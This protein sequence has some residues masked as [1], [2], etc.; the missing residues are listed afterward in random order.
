MLKKIGTIFIFKTRIPLLKRESVGRL[1]ALALAPMCIA[2]AA[3]LVI[4]LITLP[5]P[6]EAIHN[7]W[8]TTMELL[9]LA[10]APAMVGVTAGLHDW[11]KAEQKPFSMLSVVF[12]SMCAVVTSSV[13]FSVLTLSNHTAFAEYQW[14]RLLFSFRWPSIVYALDILAWDVFFPLA[15]TFAALSVQGAGIARLVKALLY[16]SAAF[17]FFGL[18]GVPLGNMNIRNIGII[19]YLVLFPIAAVLF[20]KISGHQQAQSA[21]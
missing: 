8:F 2:Y 4:G 7:P 10:I 20:A 19:G 16:L 3:V 15:A 14:A 9:I 21:A 12:M 18:A 13:H 17:S 11:T 1:S 5:S 6:D